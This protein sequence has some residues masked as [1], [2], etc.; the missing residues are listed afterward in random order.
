MAIRTGIAPTATTAS[1][2]PMATI[3]NL[4]RDE[5]TAPRKA[6]AR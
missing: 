3:A 4:P 6:N 2:A 1:A 5:L